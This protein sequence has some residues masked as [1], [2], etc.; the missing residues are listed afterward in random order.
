MNL[1][2]II[3]FYEQLNDL[4]RCTHSLSTSAVDGFQLVIQD[5]AS[6]TVDLNGCFAPGIVERNPQNV[7]FAANV[8]RGVQRAQGDVIAIV[9][10]DI[11]AAPSVT[12]I[13]WN[14]ALMQH[15]EDASVGIVAPRL[16]F[17][18]GAVQSVG[19]AFDQRCQPM[20]RC[21]GWA[22]LQAPELNAVQDVEWAT[23][24]FLMVSRSLFEQVG[25]FDLRYAPSYFEDVDLCLKIRELG[26]RVVLDPRVSFF[27]KVGSTGGS[28]HFQRSA[29]QFRDAWVSNGKVKPGSLMPI[30]R[31]W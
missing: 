14:A 3:P 4:I 22:N 23:G 2:I 21:L 17:P 7:G 18:N 30:M 29:L 15:F 13:G 28:P 19:G 6:P 5:D 26:Y 1:S 8:N 12:P 20:H 11:Y 27:H 10:Q 31:Y 24:A 9:N 16:L 25:G